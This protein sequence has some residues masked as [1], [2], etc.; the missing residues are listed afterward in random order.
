MS[1]GTVT[2]GLVWSCTSMVKVPVPVL[3]AASVAE[4]LTVVVPMA[5]VPP[6]VGVQVTTGLAG[7]ASVAVGVKGTVAPAGLVALTVTL[8]TVITGGVVSMVQV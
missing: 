8:P 7:L 1:A 5:K 4:Q 3:P 2:V 6:A